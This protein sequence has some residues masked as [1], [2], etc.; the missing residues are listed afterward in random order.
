MILTAAVLSQYTRVTDR[1]QTT[2]YYDYSRKL[3][4]NGRLIKSKC[5]VINKFTT[6]PLNQICDIMSKS[7]ANFS[8]V[9]KQEVS[10]SDNSGTLHAN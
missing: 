7:S 9:W 5:Q 4:C 1:R 10:T 2:T 8:H 3:H 6:L